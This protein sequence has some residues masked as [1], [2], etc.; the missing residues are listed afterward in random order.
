MTR[1][2]SSMGS[3]RSS[4]PLRLTLTSSL[5]GNTSAVNASLLEVPRKVYVARLRRQVH[6]DLVVLL[7]KN[8]KTQEGQTY[9]KRRTLNR[10]RSSVPKRVKDLPKV[11]HSTSLYGKSWRGR[12][13][14]SS[15]DLPTWRSSA[16][17]AFVVFT[18]CATRF[19]WTR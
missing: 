6:P 18:I 14:Q 3:Y 19:S 16:R 10:R 5:A 15:L 1:L 4:L 2:G 7:R 11:G 8:A 17:T 12:T 13:M 9:Q